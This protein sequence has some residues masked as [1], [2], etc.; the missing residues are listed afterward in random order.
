LFPT[1]IPENFLGILL[2]KGNKNPLVG[3]RVLVKKER[4]KVRSNSGVWVYAQICVAA[5]LLAVE[6]GIADKHKYKRNCK[7]CK[8]FAVSL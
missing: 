6:T 3:C 8:Y 1:F 4:Q 5:R 7:I 2:R